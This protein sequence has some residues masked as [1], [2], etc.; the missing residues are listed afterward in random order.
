MQKH[1]VPTLRK[2][3]E[4]TGLGKT[5]GLKVVP[6]LVPEVALIKVDVK[7]ADDGSSLVLFVSNFFVN[8]D[9]LEVIKHALGQHK[10][11]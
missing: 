2:V 5:V 6:C 10:T 3:I 11:D 4:Q 8:L 1:L 9:D 7:D